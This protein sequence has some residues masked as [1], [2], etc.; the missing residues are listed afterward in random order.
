MDWDRCKLK[1]RMKVSDACVAM[2]AD[3]EERVMNKGDSNK[4]RKK[5]KKKR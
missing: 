4:K 2:R 1:L 5:K 3:A